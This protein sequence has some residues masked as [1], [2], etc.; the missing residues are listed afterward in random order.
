M[1]GLSLLPPHRPTQPNCPSAGI[2]LIL[3]IGEAQV[4]QHILWSLR[5]LQQLCLRQLFPTSLALGPFFPCGR[6]GK[7]ERCKSC[8]IRMRG[9]GR[10]RQTEQQLTAN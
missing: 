6:K 9:K 7:G 10:M 3:I 8:L 4:F 1:L 2:I 5:Q